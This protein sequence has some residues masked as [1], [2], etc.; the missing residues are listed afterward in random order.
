MFQPRM[1]SKYLSSCFL[2]QFP[3]KL[4]DYVSQENPNRIE[5][6]ERDESHFNSTER[7]SL[8]CN[9]AQIVNKLNF[10]DF[11]ELF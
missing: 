4:P 1:K 10:K 11:A 2:S 3:Y 9:L 8:K 7:K 6:K 5:T